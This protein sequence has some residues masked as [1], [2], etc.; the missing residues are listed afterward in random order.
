MFLRNLFSDFIIYK[1][2]KQAYEISAKDGKVSQAS[3]LWVLNEK[4]IPIS[5]RKLQ[6]Q[7]T[8]RHLI[9]KLLYLNS[10]NQI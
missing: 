8:V 6:I 4:K 5:N 1:I 2:S 10:L 9:T 3:A 7:F